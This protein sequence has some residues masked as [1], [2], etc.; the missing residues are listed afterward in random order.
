VGGVTAFSGPLVYIRRYHRSFP[1]VLVFV[2]WSRPLGP[3]LR[4][5]QRAR[6]VLHRPGGQ[7]PR[8][9]ADRRL[10]QLRQPDNQPKSHTVPQILSA[11]IS[12]AHS[13]LT[14]DLRNKVRNHALEKIGQ[15]PPFSLGCIFYLPYL[16][17]VFFYHF[18][19]PVRDH[20][21]LL[22]ATG[23]RLGGPPRRPRRWAATATATT[24]VPPPPPPGE[25]TARDCIRVES[26]NCSSSSSPP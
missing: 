25:S 14:A 6:G 4:R 12:R 5:R 16:L 21:C 2:R 1:L 8:Q 24:P 18:I 9:L 23:Q 17:I 13:N 19:C 20:R 15:F 26:L 22:A 10:S 11:L 3:A 7:P